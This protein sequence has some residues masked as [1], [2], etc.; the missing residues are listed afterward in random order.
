MDEHK[1]LIATRFGRSPR[2]PPCSALDF[3]D[4]LESP[5][6]GPGPDVAAFLNTLRPTTTDG[7]S[8][9]L[10]GAFCST[11][12]DLPDSFTGAAPVSE[13]SPPDATKDG[14]QDEWDILMHTMTRDRVRSG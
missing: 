14:A 8:P 4:S 13:L 1:Q 3:C 5:T 6:D 10:G 7:R 9:S 11:L 2:C 12:R